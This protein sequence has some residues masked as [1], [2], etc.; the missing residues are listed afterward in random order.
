MTSFERYRNNFNKFEAYLHEVFAPL[1]FTTVDSVVAE[2]IDNKMEDQ[3]KI[4]LT[5]MFSEAKYVDMFL[6][7]PQLIKNNEMNIKVLV[8]VDEEICT[9]SCTINRAK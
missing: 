2:I 7:M 3:I 4:H 9:I 5:E 1:A 8:S 6:D